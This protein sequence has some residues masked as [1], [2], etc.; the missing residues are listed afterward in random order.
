MPSPLMRPDEFTRGLLLLAPDLRE[1][2]DRLRSCVL[3]DDDCP[4]YRIAGRSLDLAFRAALFEQHDWASVLVAEAEYYA[5]AEHHSG[6]CPRRARRSPPTMGPRRGVHRRI[7][8]WADT[9]PVIA[10]TDASWKKGY[11]GLGYIT[12]TGRWGLCGR[13]DDRDDPTGPAKVLVNELRAVDLL[14]SALGGVPGL[15]LLVDSRWALAYL[16]AWQSGRTDAMPDGYDLRPRR[17]GAPTLVRLAER[18]AALPDLR[19]EHVKGHS[20]HLLNEAADSLAKIA[21]RRMTESFDATARA[22]DLAASFLL[23][24]HQQAALAA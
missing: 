16:Q 23:T 15:L 3:C 2:A 14:L 8:R 20:G 13:P 10:A 11:G 22:A 1:R 7:T 21:R 6:S 9:T 24:W 4:Y 18:V 5:C 12:T 17:A 19:L